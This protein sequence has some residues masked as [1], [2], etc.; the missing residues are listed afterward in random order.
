MENEDVI[1]NQMEDTRTSLTEK[2][3]SLETQV[4][5]TVQ[6]ATTNVADTVEAVKDTVESVKESVQETVATVKESVDNTI[7]A[8]K[9]TVQ[10]GVTAV[11]GFF[12]VPH[13]VRAHPWAAFGVSIAAGFFLESFVGRARARVR[14]YTSTRTAAHTPYPDHISGETYDE[15]Q[16]STASSVSSFVK[17]FEPELAKLKGLAL[18]TLVN[19]IRDAVMR[20]VPQKFAPT[21]NEV[22]DSVTKKLAGGDVDGHSSSSSMP[23]GTNGGRWQS[24]E[25]VNR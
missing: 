3:E 22:L 21:V 23:S 8:V 6:G 18:T 7:S 16:R 11:K 1:R 4:T 10:E 20:S 25:K 2:L 17:T 15:P 24:S 19:A 13:H 12:D 9:E 14:A 5:S